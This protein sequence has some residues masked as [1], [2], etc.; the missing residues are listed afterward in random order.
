MLSFALTILG[1]GRI[2]ANAVGAW[3]SRR[4]L[5]ELAC[6]ALVAFALVQHFQLKD[7]R[8]DRDAWHRQFDSEHRARLDDRAAYEK[9]Q[10]EAASNNKAH[11]AQIEQQYQRNSDDERQAYLRDLAELKRLRQQN[12][13][14]SGAPGTAGPS[15]AP[16]PSG[17]ADGD[18]L[19]LSTDEHLQASEIE[20]R[21]LH[22]QNWVL[23]QLNVNPNTE[24][25]H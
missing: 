7:A 4:S 20:L 11:V 10:A 21:L 25:A 14:P 19:H 13:A 23:K 6:I 22:L 1:Y 15:P 8:H 2:A 9:A 24:A 5:A 16:A 3:L 18:G 17:G 12:A